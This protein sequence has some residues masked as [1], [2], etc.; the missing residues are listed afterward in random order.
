V[1][2]REN[3]CLSDA[4]RPA[5]APAN[6]PLRY[7]SDCEIRDLGAAWF[8]PAQ[9]GAGPQSFDSI[10]S[11]RPSDDETCIPINRSSSNV[12]GRTT[13]APKKFTV[14][15]V[16]VSVPVPEPRAVI[17]PAALQSSCQSLPY[18]CNF[19]SKY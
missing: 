8:V 1:A 15:K 7:K 19:K 5:H 17:S 6:F 16:F 3:R 18:Y 10:Y 9:D 13:K 11:Y 14:T 12:D 2:T 4:S